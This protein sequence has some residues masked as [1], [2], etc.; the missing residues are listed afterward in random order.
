MAKRDADDASSIRA[1]LEELMSDDMRVL[2][3]QCDQVARTF[4]RRHDVGISDYDALLHIRVAEAAGE[5]L[6]LSRLKQR[7]DMSAAAVTYLVDR[8]I[9]AGH[10]RRDPD[11]GDR[12]KSL[13]RYER[14][15]M[16]V[17]GAF[18]TPLRAHIGAAVTDLPDED[19]AAA[20]R[21]FAAISAAMSSFNDE[22]RSEPT[23]ADA[24][25][26][27]ATAEVSRRK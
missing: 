7:M 17:A 6:T 13:L 20:H 8:M 4:A 11:P 12:R 3:A 23:E 14:H 22:V 9:D 2:A 27:R 1:R 10:I 19:L 16:A 5:P 18:F 26:R 25:K 15:G 24:G 21:V